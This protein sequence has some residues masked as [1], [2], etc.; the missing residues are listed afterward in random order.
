MVLG[1]AKEVSPSFDGAA[2][3]TVMA[4]SP[5]VQTHDFTWR[6]E[7]TVPLVVTQEITGSLERIQ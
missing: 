7:I 3:G 4:T 2:T 5:W 6:R 1:M